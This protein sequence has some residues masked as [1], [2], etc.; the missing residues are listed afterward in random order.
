MRPSM[1]SSREL[2]LSS[3]TLAFVCARG[4]GGLSETGGREDR[5]L[6]DNRRHTSL[7]VFGE[8]N[9]SEGQ[10]DEYIHDVIVS[11]I[12]PMTGRGGGKGSMGCR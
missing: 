5:A 11:D 1:D 6:A 3:A 12:I 2:L 8:G 7:R 9:W 4:R 10:S